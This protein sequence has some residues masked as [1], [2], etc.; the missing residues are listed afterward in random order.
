MNI[1][2]DK[3]ISYFYLTEQTFTFMVIVMFIHSE[4]KKVREEKM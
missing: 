2:A 1:F 4:M 3:V